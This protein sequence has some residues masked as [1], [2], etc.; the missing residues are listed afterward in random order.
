M[1]QVVDRVARTLGAFTIERPELTLMECANA[2]ELTKSSAHRLLS[3]LEEVELVERIGTRWRLGPRI[4]RLATVRLGQIDLRSEAA[5]R[6]RE[7]GSTHHAAVAFSVPNGSDMIY[8]ERY[9]SPDAVGINARL[10][11]MAAIWAGGSGRAV[12]ACLT[13]EE[14]ERR[15]ADER[16]RSLPSETRDAVLGE[17]A[18]AERIGYCVELQSRFWPGIGGIAVAIRD[19]HG[20]PVAAISVIM[21]PDRL[22]EDRV[23]EIGNTLVATAR[24]LESLTSLGVGQ[25]DGQG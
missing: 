5:P 16:W 15:L 8:L 22:T 20:V 21:P 6:L 4:V 1:I 14:R 25:R 2:A 3:S 10:G 23:T 9:E 19:A 17:I 7:L 18:E 24:E 12:L 13:P 11:G